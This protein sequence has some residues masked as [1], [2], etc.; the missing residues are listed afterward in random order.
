MAQAAFSA[1]ATDRRQE[2]GRDD[3]TRRSIPRERQNPTI[4]M[5]FHLYRLSKRSS[6]GICS[7]ALSLAA[8]VAAHFCF[9]HPALAQS[10]GHS[11][12]RLEISGHPMTNLVVDEK[13]QGWLAIEGVRASTT[14]SPH[15]ATGAVGSKD[16]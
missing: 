5:K 9:A 2:S 12:M 15:R 11:Y 1:P 16:E 6:D 10:D 3:R 4:A 14:Q 7:A 13:Y 8:I